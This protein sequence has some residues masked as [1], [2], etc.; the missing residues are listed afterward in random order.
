MRLFVAIDIDN[1]IKKQI[2][3]R[4]K[5]LNSPDFRLKLVEPVNLHITVKFLGE[6]NEDSVHDIEN[7]ISNVVKN[8]EPFTLSLGNVGFFGSNNYI[9]V[10]WI[11]VLDGKEELVNIIEQ[12]NEKLKYVRDENHK[13][14][15]HVT[16]A[17]VKFGGRN[18]R[19]LHKIKEMSNVKFGE[20]FVKHLSLKKSELSRSGPI[21]TDVKQFSLGEQHN[22]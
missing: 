3:E 2:G 4:M 6:V 9:R 19:L 12:M 13:P 8:I 14:N 22:E 15:P 21:Y 11:D 5:Q 17:R 7:K 1:K 16:I 10:I 18:D 20:M